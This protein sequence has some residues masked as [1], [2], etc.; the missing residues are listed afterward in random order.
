M[1]IHVTKD[2]ASA[3]VLPHGRIQA[4]D[5]KTRA[6]LHGVM[7]SVGTFTFLRTGPDGAMETVEFKDDDAEWLALTACVLQRA[8]WDARVD[9]RPNPHGAGRRGDHP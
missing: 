4:A 5:P 7:S 3:K 9:L 8:G 2:R 1:I 6:E